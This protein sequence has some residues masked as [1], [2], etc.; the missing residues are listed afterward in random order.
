MPTTTNKAI[1]YP[2]A[3]DTPDVPRDI[4]ALANRV[5]ALLG[6]AETPA[7]TDLNAVTSQGTYVLD[8]ATNAPTAASGWYVDVVRVSSSVVRQIATL[9]GTTSGAMWA[10]TMIGGAWGAWRLLSPH[11]R[12]SGQAATPAG[13]SVAVTFPAG[14]FT[15]TP[16]VT[17]GVV[18][19]SMPSSVVQAYVSSPSSSGFTLRIHSSSALAGGIGTA[20][21]A[22][23]QETP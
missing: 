15:A 22:A 12:T 13:G 23:V 19:S 7:S 6:T 2:V 4:L 3:T 14:L 11:A 5:D 10:R 9:S 1:P 16:R 17:L 20:D 8:A 18:T 21:Y